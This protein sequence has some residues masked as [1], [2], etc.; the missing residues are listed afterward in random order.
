MEERRPRAVVD[1]T[2]LAFSPTLATSQR[3]QRRDNVMATRIT[4]THAETR[5]SPCNDPLLSGPAFG[6]RHFLQ[7]R[8]AS[9][10]RPTD[11]RLDS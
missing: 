4:T 11:A 2:R 6:T 7:S 3:T 8:F 9:S 5:L 10:L 1:P